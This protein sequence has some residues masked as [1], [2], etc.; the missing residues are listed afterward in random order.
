MMSRQ[1]VRPVLT[2]YS[3]LHSRC[4]D[5]GDDPGIEFVVALA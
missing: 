4:G 2:R 3:A 1:E 5:D